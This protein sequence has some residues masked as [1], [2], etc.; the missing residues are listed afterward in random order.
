MTELEFN[1]K[2]NIAYNEC[3]K[4]LESVNDKIIPLANYIPCK[5]INN[6]V[7]VSGQLPKDILDHNNIIKGIAIDNNDIFLAKYAAVMC[8]IQIL[9]ILKEKL[10][11]L[12]KIKSFIQLQ[13]FVNSNTSFTNQHLVANG[14]SD[15]ICHFLGQEIGQHSRFAVGVSSL[16]LG[17]I[18]EIGA[19][20]A[21]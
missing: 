7:Y 19:N 13:V 15:V 20:I 4:I 3:S 17:A 11:D 9:L 2:I 1:E 6:I 8:G 5:I 14:A 21:V 10:G 16:P 12:N 18:V